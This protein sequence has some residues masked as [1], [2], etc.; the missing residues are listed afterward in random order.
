MSSPKAPEL[1]PKAE[2]G[3]VARSPEAISAILRNALPQA[4]G[5]LL[6]LSGGGDSLAV[7]KC[8]AGAVPL[9]ALHVNHGLG[10][11]AGEMQAAAEAMALR[12]G[13]PCESVKLTNP[14]QSNVE[15]WAR[16][17]RYEVLR[18]AQRFNEVVITA[19]HQDDQAESF[20]LAAARASGPAGLRGIVA[21]QS[22]GDGVLVRPAL[23]MSRAELQSVLGTDDVWVEDRANENPRFDRSRLRRDVMPAI[24]H[25]KPEAPANIARAAAQWASTYEH[26]SVLLDA[27]ADEISAGMPQVWRIDALLRLPDDVRGMLLR[28]LGQQAGAPRIPSALLEEL[29]RQL[30]SGDASSVILEWQGWSFR[31]HRKRLF[32]LPPLPP[33]KVSPVPLPA[34]DGVVWDPGGR[35][36][37]SGEFGGQWAIGAGDMA[38]AVAIPRANIHKTVQKLFQEYG[39][40]Y[41]VRPYW[42]QLLRDDQPVAL[43]EFSITYPPEVKKLQWIQSPLW[44][45][46][47]V[48]RVRARA[49]AQAFR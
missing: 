29:P 39:V 2:H 45:R 30:Q 26:W 4:P 10:E 20:I 14:A 35:L 33:Q 37:I 12:Y 21:V 28:R 36:E 43:A 46:P 48:E 25:W 24:R 13:V 18:S 40:P 31:P 27:Y 44:V 16:N 49:Q 38:S 41:W 3:S 34:Q 22:F 5:Y 9:R 6:A 7:L 15:E 32:L 47:W 42:P 8:L 11:Q 23:A 1:S 17:A 19:H